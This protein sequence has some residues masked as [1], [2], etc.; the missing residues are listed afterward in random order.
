MKYSVNNQLSIF[1]FHDCEFSLIS[2]E[3]NRLVVSAKYLNIHKDA[4][5]NPHDC[6]MEIALAQIT[7]CGFEILAFEP[8]RDYTLD[9]DGNW[10]TDQPQIIF[11]GEEAKTH[12]I[13]EIKRGIT[14]NCIENCEENKK[15]IIEISTC[16]QSDFFATFAFDGVTVEW[17]EYRKKA[18]YELHKQYKHE[19]MLI[20]PNGL[21]KTDVHIVC[22][23]ED[24]YY[25]GELEKAPIVNVGIE[26]EGNEIWGRGKDYLW[27]DAFANLQKQLPEG[28]ILKCCLTCR[29]GNMC[30]YGNM[31]GEIFCT[32][33][34]VITSKKDMCDLYTRELLD[35][36]KI[37]NRIRSYFNFC[38]EYQHQSWEFYTYNDYL[39]E[40]D[41]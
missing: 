38:E 32:K 4:E 11:N 26:Y 18:W 28:V 17:D 10:H 29:H 36:E 37:K 12:F 41:K 30:P 22:H 19:I 33:D 23:E 24:V 25:Q 5:H 20:T 8:M 9:D 39:Y 40:L 7:F 1:E 3:N 15:T 14:I 16:G 13:G 21:L 6:D 35:N 34:C 27:V 2:F 31:P